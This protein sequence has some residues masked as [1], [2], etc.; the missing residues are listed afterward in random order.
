VVKTAVQIG[1]RFGNI[2]KQPVAAEQ[3][4]QGN[5]P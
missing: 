3:V 5:T 4:H 1:R 2:G